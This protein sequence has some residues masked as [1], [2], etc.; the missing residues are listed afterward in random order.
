MDV[1]SL[2][3]KEEFWEQ[4]ACGAYI[5][6]VCQPEAAFDLSTAAQHQ[7]PTKDD[8]TTL[9]KR[10]QLQK[11]NLTHRIYFISIDLTSTKVFVF[12]DRSFA[13]NQDLT[14][15]I[16]YVIAMG[17]DLFSSIKDEFTFQGNVIHWSSTKCKRVVRSVLASELYAIV[18]GVDIAISLGSTLKMVT[19]QLGV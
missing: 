4:Q 18:A 14:S 17:N 8:V 16:G 6:S 19:Q 11:D 1:K 5:S 13:N 2:T 7:E 15:Q 12:V 10:L 3:F 9:N